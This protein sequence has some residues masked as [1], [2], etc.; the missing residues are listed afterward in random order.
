MS[1]LQLQPTMKLQDYQANTSV[2]GDVHAKN[3]MMLG[4]RWHGSYALE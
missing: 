4:V 3:E 1:E 2:Q